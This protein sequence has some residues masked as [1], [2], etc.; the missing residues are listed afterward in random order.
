MTFVEST[1]CQ[2]SPQPYVFE[3]V[4]VTGCTLA[5]TDSN[6]QAWCDRFLNI[7]DSHQFRPLMPFV[8]ACVSHYPKMF[9]EGQEDL[10]YTSQNEFFFMFPVIRY[11]NIWG[12][13]FPTELSW[14]FPYIGVTNGTSAI[15]G[16]AVLGFPKMLGTITMETGSDGIFTAAVAM[17]GFVRRDRNTEQE[18]LPV[19]AIRTGAPA[20]PASPVVAAG[21]TITDAPATHPFPWS[22]VST[23]LLTSTFEDEIIDL[24][25]E[26]DPGLFSV[27]NL[28]QI[29][30]AEH[31]TQ[32]CYQSLVRAEWRLADSAM[33]LFDGAEVDVFDNT[34]V[35]IAADLGLVGGTPV[36]SAPLGGKPAPGLRVQAIAAFS[37]HTDMR[38][39]DVTNLE[40]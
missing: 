10:G 15:S 34:S 33:T 40:L 12:V 4:S 18:I 35:A 9:I 23:G 36:T 26:I 17:P 5:A 8:W 32:A 20:S 2:Q 24:L 1:D 31:S 28:K 14:A 37:M 38:F 30:D 13:W 25:E 21:P 39:G 27:T 6:L 3:A 11:S 7:G 29:R 16:Q 22:L 19:V